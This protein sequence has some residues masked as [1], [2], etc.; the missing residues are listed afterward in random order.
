MLGHG[1]GAAGAMETLAC[2]FAIRDNQIPPT[3]NLD[4][5]DP[6]CD[7]DY[8]PHVARP[9]QVDIVLKNSFGMGNQNVCLV[10]RRYAGD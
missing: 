10:L 5:P 3:I 9:A 4:T 2:I 6:E 1:L 8:V 7:L